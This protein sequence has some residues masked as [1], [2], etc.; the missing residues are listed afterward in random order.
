MDQFIIPRKRQTLNRT[1]FARVSAETDEILERLAAESRQQK[2]ALVRLAVEEFIKRARVEIENG[3]Q[4]A[5]VE[6]G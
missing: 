6:A 1:V 3:E 5:A 4:A 2:S